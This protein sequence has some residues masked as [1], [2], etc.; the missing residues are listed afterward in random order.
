M[1]N[2]VRTVYYEYVPMHFIGSEIKQNVDSRD[3]HGD[4]IETEAAGIGHEVKTFGMFA[5]VLDLGPV[6][7]WLRV[8]IIMLRVVQGRDQNHLQV[9]EFGQ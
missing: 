6:E 9:F 3:R 4:P 1:P 7:R 5:H 2:R 8:H